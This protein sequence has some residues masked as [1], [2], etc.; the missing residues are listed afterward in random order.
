MLCDKHCV[1]MPTETA[2]ILCTV[3][4]FSNEVAAQEL[5]NMHGIYKPA[6]KTWHPSIRWVAES[7][8][9]YDW[10]VQLLE[11]L[12]K[13]YT[14]RYGKTHACERFVQLFRD[15]IGHPPLEK[16]DWITMSQQFQAIADES[17]KDDDP[18]VAYRAFYWQDK[19]RF[20]KWANGR[21]APEWWSQLVVE[22]E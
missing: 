3:W 21:D 6:R 11:E 4:W 1:K 20:A 17:L 19:R 14:F 8:A 9:N 13:E 12:C 18:V 15:T 22:N 16:F 10:T 2:Q 5:M 7:T